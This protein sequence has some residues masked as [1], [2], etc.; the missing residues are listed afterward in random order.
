M[1]EDK[2]SKDTEEIWKDIKGYE[3]IYQV[4]SEGRIKSVERDII[5]KNGAKHHYKEKILKY[6]FNSQGYLTINI[7]NKGKGKQLRVH[8]LVA[9]A[10]IPNPENKSQVNHKNE[11]K[12]DNRVENLEWMSTK[13]NINY[14]THNER[15][16]KARSKS[17]A[18]YSKDGKL[19]E[20][21]SSARE[22]ARQLSIKQGPISNV[23]RGIQKT[24]YG[25]I[26]KYVED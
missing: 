22:A 10:F 16:A 21:W 5:Y 4:S 12:T 2:E 18:Q 17:V 14:G 7:Y 24:A 26:W 19:L 1:Q 6:H 23:A 11:I 9:E 13:E 8:R 20:V 25:Y 3:G 15:S